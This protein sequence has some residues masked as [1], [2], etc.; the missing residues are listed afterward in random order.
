[1]FSELLKIKVAFLNTTTAGEKYNPKWGWY[2][3]R[4]SGTLRL[5]MI[6]VKKI[7]WGGVLLSDEQSSN[8]LRI[9][10]LP[11]VTKQA[12]I[13]RICPKCPLFIQEINVWYYSTYQRQA[14]ILLLVVV[15]AFQVR[16][17]TTLY[18]LLMPPKKIN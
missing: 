6:A 5:W 18:F 12:A 15:K 2:F 3:H 7:K 9:K 16:I 4:Y 13:Q 17:L 14:E 11:S 10:S 1:M 8:R